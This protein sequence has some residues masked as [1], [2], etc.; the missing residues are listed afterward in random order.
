[1]SLPA[2]SLVRVA[3]Q[4]TGGIARLTGTTIGTLG[5]DTANSVTVFT[6]GTYGS[7]VISLIASSSDV[8]NNVLI[9]ILRG[10]TVVPIGLVAVAAGSGNANA[11]RFVIDFLN[12]T[13]I[14]GLPLDNTGRQYIPMLGGDILRACTLANPSVG[15]SIW[16]TS[17][18]LDYLAP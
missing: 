14:P 9:Y 11:T 2:G 7:R 4:P 5:N 10:P 16:L 18:S 12:G 3:N 8:A 17:S 6:A 15:T 13:N 1:M